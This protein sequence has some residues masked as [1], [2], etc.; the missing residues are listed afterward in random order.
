LF[1]VVLALMVL[2]APLVA[3][4]PLPWA[5]VAL[6][7]LWPLVALLTPV[8]RSRWRMNVLWVLAA[9]LAVQLIVTLVASSGYWPEWLM[10]DDEDYS[11]ET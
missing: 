2:T 8:R 10:F 9:A 5:L 3:W 7:L 6:P 4:V 1:L 11:P